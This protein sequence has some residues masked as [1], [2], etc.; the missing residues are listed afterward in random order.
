[1]VSR[2]DVHDLLSDFDRAL[3]DIF[4]SN[5]K[6]LSIVRLQK[7]QLFYCVIVATPSKRYSYC[8]S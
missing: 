4:Q 7:K 5:Q 8:F 6:W 2:T 3:D 1:M